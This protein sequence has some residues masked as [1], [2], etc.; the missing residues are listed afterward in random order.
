VG[1]DPS[2]DD[3]MIATGSGLSRRL[4][5]AHRGDIPALA[6]IQSRCVD[7]MRAIRVCETETWLAL[8]PA[9]DEDLIDAGACYV[10]EVD[11][12]PAGFVAWEPAEATM[13][14]AGIA[15]DK[16]VLL[17]GDAG[18]ALLRGIYVDPGRRGRGLGRLLLERVEAGAREAGRARLAAVGPDS[19]AAFFVGLG[20]GESGWLELSDGHGARCCLPVL[21]RPLADACGPKWLKFKD[22]TMS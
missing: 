11:G 3:I 1:H 10:A 19:S 13:L 14:L 8:A 22:S 5:A 4:R 16:P 17:A 6:A 2:L 9:V 20:Y 21:A 15:C 18:V 12:A 7:A